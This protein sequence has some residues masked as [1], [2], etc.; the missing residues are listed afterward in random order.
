MPLDG[1]ARIAVERRADRPARSRAGARPRRRARRRDRRSDAC[2]PLFQQEV[3][4]ERLVG[5]RDRRDLRFH[6]RVERVGA[7]VVRLGHRRLCRRVG[8]GRRLERPIPAAA[9]ERQ[10]EQGAR[11]PARGG[12]QKNEAGRPRRDSRG[13]RLYTAM[14][15]GGERRPSP[16]LVSGKVERLPPVLLAKGREAL[17]LRRCRRERPRPTVADSHGRRRHALLDQSQ[18]EARRSACRR[19]A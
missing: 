12:K 13:P 2:R 18:L 17:S 9:G 11:A 5:R 16:P 7:E 14:A 15:R 6:L 8:V 19:R 1:R 3:E 10:R 4:K